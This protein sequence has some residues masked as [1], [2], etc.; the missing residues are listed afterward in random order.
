[1]VTRNTLIDIWSYILFVLA[2]PCS[3]EDGG[4]D[5]NLVHDDDGW[6]LDR[7]P[8]MTCRVPA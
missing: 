3:N 2:I 1:M 7:C 5:P 4:T 8:R 6:R